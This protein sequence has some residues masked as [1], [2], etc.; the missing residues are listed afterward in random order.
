VKE[1]LVAY[2]ETQL[3][4]YMVPQL[5][6][7]LP[8]LPMTSHGK[9]DKKVLSSETAQYQ[10][11]RSYVPAATELESKLVRIWEELLQVSPVGTNDSFFELG[12]HSLLAMRMTS[13]IQK[14]LD[15][16]VPVKIIF[17]CKSI[18]KLAAYIEELTVKTVRLGV[19]VI[20]L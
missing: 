2:L 14:E 10:L 6:V 7:A 20:S 18:D 16:N 3:P 15:V 1:D 5:Y 4:E 13:S 9:L 17:Q 8:A 11:S 12:G 19:N